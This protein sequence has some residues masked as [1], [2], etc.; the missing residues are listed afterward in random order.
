MRRAS[1]RASAAPR[2][3]SGALSPGQQAL[4]PS[5]HL[6]EVSA[7]VLQGLSPP[8]AAEMLLRVDPVTLVG[9]SHGNVRHWRNLSPRATSTRDTFLAAKPCAPVVV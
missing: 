4:L 2:G 3:G 1:A 9:T 5:W 6:P 7:N 8:R